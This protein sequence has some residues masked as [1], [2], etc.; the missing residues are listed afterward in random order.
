MAGNPIRF[1]SSSWP[2]RSI[3]SLLLPG[4]ILAGVPVAELQHVRLRLLD[5]G[6]H[7]P[8]VA[9]TRVR[10]VWCVLLLSMWPIDLLPVL[11]VPVMVGGLLFATAGSLVYPDTTVDLIVF[12]PSGIRATVTGLLLAVLIAAAGAYLLTCLAAGH[13]VLARRSLRLRRPVAVR[14]FDAERRRIERD[15]HDGTQQ[16]L[17]SLTM[18]LG[19]ARIGTPGE[20][21]TLVAEAH[22]D[23]RRAIAE[24]R[25]VVHGVRPRVLIEQGL[26]A[27]LTDL[28]RRSGVPVRVE[29][30]LPDRPTAVVESTVYFVVSEAL[31][32]VAKHAQAT[33]V[34]V[35]G[36]LSA[37]SLIV[38][39]EDDGVGG[40][41][42]RPGGGLDGLRDRAAAVGG[43]LALVSP[44]GGPTVVRLS[45]PSPA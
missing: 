36:G 30:A 39:V 21:A 13:A 12:A 44:R 26:P 33:S 35:R 22:E 23:A 40:A 6:G 15:L 1:L 43:V 27:A 20:T 37:G 28:A 4:L 31:A 9:H 16:R 42:V 2:W 14:R 17:I 45:V 32:N 38:E 41:S 8:P 11:G 25:E 18:K 7:R 34:T 10:P 29:V 24:L 5:P 19:I 3:A